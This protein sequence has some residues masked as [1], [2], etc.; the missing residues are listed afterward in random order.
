LTGY[1]PYAILMECPPTDGVGHPQGA[2][3]EA[4]KTALAH[5]AFTKSLYLYL[6][7]NDGS[8]V[9]GPR[10]EMVR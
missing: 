2:S 6:L 9:S 5:M 4:I 10:R 8:S 1:L 3:W 7:V